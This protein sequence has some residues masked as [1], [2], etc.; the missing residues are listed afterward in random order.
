MDV[1]L[2]SDH[3]RRSPLV[4]GRLEIK[5]KVTVKVPNATPRQVTER[6][7]AFV[8]ELHVEPKEE[9]TLGLFNV[10][11]DSE[12]MDEDFSIHQRSTTPR[13]QPSK[14]NQSTI[15][16]KV[17]TLE[18]FLIKKRSSCLYQKIIIVID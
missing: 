4:Q 16:S 7:L 10:V 11:N 8:K 6:Y 9:E 17:K 13:K 12:N 5:C 18:H 3:Y 15:K 1:E 2:T 14:L